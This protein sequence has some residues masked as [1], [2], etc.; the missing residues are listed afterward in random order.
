[1]CSH[2]ENEILKC[3]DNDVM[4][5]VKRDKEKLQRDEEDIQKF[6]LENVIYH[7]TSTKKLLENI[8]P[9]KELRL[10]NIKK[11]NDP[12]ENL[13]IS[14]RTGGMLPPNNKEREEI[15][16][17][18]ER[19]K[20]YI[21]QKINKNIRCVCFCRNNINEKGLDYLGFFKTRMWAQYGDDFN[22]ACL[23][24]NL[25]AL[26][27]KNGLIAVEVYEEENGANYENY[28]YGN[29]QYKNIAE[30]NRI[31]SGINTQDLFSKKN[32]NV[33]I[34][35]TIKDRI[36]VKNIDFKDENEL[37][38]VKFS[39]KEY[40]YLDITDCVQGII[41]NQHG[42]NLCYID[43][44]YKYSQRMNFSISTTA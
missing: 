34:G 23:A 8:L 33:I 32:R 26:I 25:E 2:L 12:F 15:R 28:I 1:M 41:I 11:T 44:I 29:I 36:Y 24:L 14:I 37:R 42:S 20:E 9:K 35:R 5:I 13:Y 10:S 30:L 6:R 7:Y 3:K 16:I 43:M 22:G 17:E 39:N 31:D 27:K 21:E 19:M 4:E 40:E 38:I 18:K